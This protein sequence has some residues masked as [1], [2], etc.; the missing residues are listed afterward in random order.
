VG[1]GGPRLA[2][3]DTTGHARL[4]MGTDGGGSPFFSMA[5]EKAVVRV[6]MTIEPFGAS[7]NLKDG[8]GVVRASLIVAGGAAG[9]AN[10]GP[11]FELFDAQRAPRAS[12]VANDVESGLRVGAGTGAGFGGLRWTAEGPRLDV[13]ASDGKP[14]FHAP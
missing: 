3:A 11:R 9:S 8:K 1:E 14:L 7:M 2:F 6:W 13:V 5:D 12:L 4:V 10:E